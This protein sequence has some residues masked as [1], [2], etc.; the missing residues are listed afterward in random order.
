[1]ACM[2]HRKI[3]L[4]AGLGYVNGWLELGTWMMSEKRM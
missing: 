4:W 3:M 2:L 1:M